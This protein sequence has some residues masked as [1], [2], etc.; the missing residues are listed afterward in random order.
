[1]S[2]SPIQALPPA[3]RLRLVARG[4]LRSLAVGVLLIA[5]S[6]VAPLHA[7]TRFPLWASLTARLVLLTAI[8]VVHVRA[9][10]RA[11]YPGLRA[12]EAVASTIPLF[13]VLFTAS[14]FLL[15]QSSDLAFNVHTLTRTNA[16]YFTITVFTT[17]VSGTSPRVARRRE[18]WSRSTWSSA[19]L[20]WACSSACYSRPV[21]PDF[22]S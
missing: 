21:R 1:M 4:L 16:L 12:V 5:L 14:Y 10:L 19:G 13:I 17:V 11:D 15:A 9:T 2:E 18:P 7:M 8:S 22:R 3:Q 20:S 6:Y